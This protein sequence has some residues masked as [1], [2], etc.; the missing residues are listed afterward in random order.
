[1]S[2]LKSYLA[3][4]YMSGPKADAI[5]AKTNKKKK[6]RKVAEAA[7]A[8]GVSFVKDED[9]GW[10]NTPAN[11]DEDDAMDVSEAVVASD[12]S[13]KKRKR[14]GEPSSGWTTVKEPTPPPEDEKP[15]VVETDTPFV[16]GLVSARQLKKV[17]PSTA[18]ADSSELTAEEI[19]RA[20][21]TV[22]RDATG[23]KID[24][25]AARADAARKKREMEEKEAQK[26]EWGK[27]LVQRDEAEERRKELAKQRLTKGFRHKDDE[28]LNRELKDKELWNDPAAAFLTVGAVVLCRTVAANSATEKEIK[29][30]TLTDLQR[31]STTAESF[32]NFSGLQVGRCRCV[33][34]SCYTILQLTIIQT[35]GT[36]LR[37]SS[38]KHSTQENAGHRRAICGVRRTCRRAR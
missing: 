7:P 27:G 14:E 1:M 37:K 18:A 2:D 19:A 10:S 38:S 5:L 23:R 31:S 29:G 21:E 24:T 25:K 33:L 32:W 36:A 9:A 4:K 28:D 17:L 12:R 26:M 15:Q 3:E 13:F 30:P 11:D 34:Y 20:Q 6:K 22:Y 8:S 35:A 16:G